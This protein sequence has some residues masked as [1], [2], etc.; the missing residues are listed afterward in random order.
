LNRFDKLKEIKELRDYEPRHDPSVV[1]IVS[2]SEQE[3]VAVEDVP[4]APPRTNPFAHYNSADYHDAYRSGRLT[5]TDVAQYLLPL[6]QR[7]LEPPGKYSVAF[8]QVRDD[9]VLE[10]AKASTERY[11]AGTCLSV[12]DGVPIAVKDEVDLT[13]YRHTKGTKLDFTD[14]GDRTAWCISKWI[15]AGAVII[16]KT[17]MHE[18]GLD[19]TNNNLN[20][21]T[22]LNPHNQGY[23]T[24]GSSGG[25]A[26]A[27]AQGLCPVALGVDGGGSIRLPASFCGLYGLKPSH[28]RV[29][30]RAGPEI[31]D[32]VG[33]NGPIASNIDD[34]ALSYRVMAQPDIGSRASASYPGT[35]VRNPAGVRSSEDKRYLGVFQD[36]VDRADPEVLDMFNKAVDHLVKTEE[37]EV[38]H[39][40]IP[41]MTEGQKAHALTI[42]SE[43]RSRV[44][45]ADISKLTYAN[46]L[47]LNV[48]GS[49][50][51]AQDFLFA[52]RL[53]NLQMSHLA[54]LFDRYP[55]MLVVTPTTP[56]AGWKI[57]SPSD[58][59]GYGVSDGDMSLRSMEYVFFA[60]WT[61][62]PAISCPMGY[63]EGDIPVGFMVLPSLVAPEVY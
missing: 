40:E 61:G 10:A 16:G 17:N 31:W 26:C 2:D 43:V 56:C 18:I 13:G 55:G 36:W 7:D 33:V 41:F 49:H 51:S 5:P 52:Q 45:K 63:A 57:K 34:L 25:S 39:I 42:L 62:C 15:E 48:A 50:A 58:T 37:C 29:S 8:I 27:V 6:I 28:G 4:Q 21:G 38:V 20:W 12:L 53:R 19:T 32:S 9:L 1:P 30:A 35:L 23:Y 59:T 54:W 11:K 44:A 24:G 22:P 60:N 3:V 46:Q 47:L 14:K